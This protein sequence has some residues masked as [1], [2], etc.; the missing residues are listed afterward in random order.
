MCSV[1]S[2]ACPVVDTDRSW[3]VTRR[4]FKADISFKEHSTGQAVVDHILKTQNKFPTHFKD[5]F[6]LSISHHPLLTN[7]TSLTM[8][9]MPI[10]A[11]EPHTSLKLGME[12]SS[13]VI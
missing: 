5:G 12:L 8:Q 9:A 13:L 6:L 1:E 7:M 3:E 2:A 10:M 4:T 11:V